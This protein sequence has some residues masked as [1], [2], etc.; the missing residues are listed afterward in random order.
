MTHTQK[1]HFFHLIWSTKNRAKL[2]DSKI[3][4][5]LYPYIGGIIRNYK[6]T[7]I[8]I[9]GMPD[10]VHLLINLRNLDKYSYLI[11]DIKA[12]STSW[13]HKNFSNVREFAWQEGFASF[14]LH[15]SLIDTVRHYIK[16]QEK[17]HQVMTF[18]DEY[19]KF[20][21]DQNIQYDKRFVFD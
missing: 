12:H 8:E 16:N 19:L 14:S 3:Q 15:F 1:F 10:H 6:G 17:H 20:L 21:D 13:A 7:L 4:S 11:R 18:E 5:N 9:G 2:I